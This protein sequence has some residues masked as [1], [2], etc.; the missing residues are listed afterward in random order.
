MFIKKLQE[1][2]I[3]LDYAAMTP[4]S[5]DVYKVM[6]PW[7]DGTYF[8]NPSSIHNKG[9]YAR[10]V[11]EDCI[12][13]VQSAIGAP[14]NSHVVFTSGGTESNMHALQ[15][16]KDGS[17]VLTTEIEH[18]SVRDLL[19]NK[20]GIEILYIPLNTDGS[21][22][23]DK[24]DTIL[25][26][27]KVDFASIM[28]V[29]NETGHVLPVRKISKSI[30]RYNPEAIIHTDASQAPLYISLR[31]TALGVDLLTLC[32]Q[33][34]YGPQGSGILWISGEV[35]ID[36]V[37]TGGKQQSTNRAGTEPL[38]QII[39]I[40]K[41]LELARLDREKY[42]K[43]MLDLQSYFLDRL[44]KSEIL[45][46]H[47]GG[48]QTLPVACNIT[49][50]D[51]DKTSEEIVSFLN[52]N[53]VYVSS[54]SACMGSVPGDSYVLKGL[55]ITAKNTVRFSFGSGSTKKDIDTVVTI[56]KKL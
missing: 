12:K 32:G 13:S 6:R 10:L 21:V 42:S 22:S 40:T 48:D 46:I 4:L 37:F 51:T 15:A 28:M 1:K 19:Q 5:R 39:G 23:F 7:L 26:E 20:Q 33:K 25:S 16:V 9:K 18:S 55:G 50:T 2:A 43:K 31:V 52:I 47:N 30:K 27:N 24:L 29:N 45:F 36:P 56:L 11:L 14:I 54:R 35:A 3:Y 44:T 49:F 53:N 38:H 34:M 8:G 41:S 17:I